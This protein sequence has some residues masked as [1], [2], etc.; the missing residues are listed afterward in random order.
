[1]PDEAALPRA[2]ICH[3]SPGRVRVR[4]PE[5][6]YDAQYFAAVRELVSAWPGVESVEVNP[7]TAGVLVRFAADPGGFSLGDFPP[8]ALGNDLFTIDLSDLADAAASG[9]HVVPIDVEVRAG[10][11]R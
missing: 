6:R 10:L 5:R 3:V 2:R 1:M 11:K 7:V 4:I 9:G 8:D